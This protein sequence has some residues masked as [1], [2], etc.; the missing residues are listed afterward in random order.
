MSRILQDRI[1][2]SWA[3]EELTYPYLLAVAGN[4]SS[5]VSQKID[6]KI[7]G[8]SRVTPW[9]NY[10]RVYLVRG[11]LEDDRLLRLAA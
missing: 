7:E 4:A 3:A 10:E 6:D 9:R 5:S 11:T 1:T 8:P 2:E